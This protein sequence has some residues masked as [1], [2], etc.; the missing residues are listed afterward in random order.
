MYPYPDNI[1]AT[2]NPTNE[3]KHKIDKIDR[4]IITIFGLPS[5][6]KG[7]VSKI[8]AKELKLPVFDTG[9]LYRVFT[10]FML[11][12]QLPELSH[13]LLLE[14]QSKIRLE[15]I[16]NTI[17][18]ELDGEKLPINIL[19]GPEIDQ[20]I[21]LY[22]KLPEVR[23]VVNKI[24]AQFVNTTSFVTDGRGA[25]DAYLMEAE[26]TGKKII[27]ILLQ[28]E[29]SERVRRRFIDYIQLERGKKLSSESVAQLWKTCEQIVQKRDAEEIEKEAKL[30]LGMV[31]EDTGILDTTNL[32]VDQVCNSLLNWINEKFTS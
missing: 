2:I 16:Q 8:V 5:T 3:F 10:Y 1:G 32:T 17:T 19:R 27:R 14:F 26:K 22:P 18:F 15:L 13:D 28:A 23:D 29:Q 9:L 6:G 31:S 4:C 24:I 11:Q 30:G 21:T 25:F 12:K 7:T 20:Y